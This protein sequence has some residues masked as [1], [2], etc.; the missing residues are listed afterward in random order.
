[1]LLVNWEAITTIAEIVGAA[2]VVASLIYSPVQIRQCTRVARADTTKDLYLASRTVILEIA[3][4]DEL[5]KIWKD[6]RK[7]ESEDVARRYAFYRSFF[8]PYELQY[9]LAGRGPLDNDIAQLYVL[10]IRMF[11]RKDYFQAVGNRLLLNSTMPSPRMSTS[12]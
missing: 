9:N 10:V 5:A 6:I 8:R 7:I 1:M 4:N 12:K 3:A 2:G 11:A